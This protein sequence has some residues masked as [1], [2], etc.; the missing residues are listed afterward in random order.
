MNQVMG[1]FTEEYSFLRIGPG[2]CASPAETAI[3]RR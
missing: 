3:S 2:A 1:V